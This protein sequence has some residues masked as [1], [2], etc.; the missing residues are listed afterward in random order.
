MRL[1]QGDFER[2]KAYD[3]DPV[4][5][6]V[7]WA[8]Q[9]ARRLHVVVL[10]GARGGEPMNLDVVERIVAKVKVPVQLGGGLRSLPDLRAAFSAGA[11]RVILGTGAVQDP[12]MLESALEAYDHRVLVSLDSRDGYVATSGWMERSEMTVTEAI[13]RLQRYGVQNFIFTDIGLDGTLDGPNLQRIKEIASTV[14][15]QFIYSGGISSLDDLREL[16][17]LRCVNLAGAIVGKAIYEERFTVADGQA[18]LLG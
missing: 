18:V 5:A 7:R 11:Q 3:A 2:E 13:Q 4:D 10:D 17:A 9:G 6:A 1:V 16:V 14:R 8:K 12:P 15:G